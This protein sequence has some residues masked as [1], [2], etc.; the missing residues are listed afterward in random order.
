ME[1]NHSDFDAYTIALKLHL[2][3]QHLSSAHLIPS[4]SVGHV[5]LSTARPHATRPSRSSGQSPRIQESLSHSI[6]TSHSLAA[7]V[8]PPNIGVS[9]PQYRHVTLNK[10]FVRI[11]LKCRHNLARHI[12]VSGSLVEIIPQCPSARNPTPSASSRDI[13][14]VG[15]LAC[16]CHLQ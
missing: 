2:S 10:G 12:L 11:D 1:S 5:I 13:V 9:S 16:V 15:S 7:A 6:D 4:P 3:F 8:S 14:L